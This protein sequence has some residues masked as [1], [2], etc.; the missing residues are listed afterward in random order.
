MM[1]EAQSDRTKPF[2]KSGPAAVISGD[3]AQLCRR[4]VT[5][6]RLE[7]L[8]L[9]ARQVLAE[10]GYTNIEF[11]FGDGTLG[12]PELGPYDGILVTAAAPSIPEPLYEQL[13]PGGRLIVPVGDE[14]GQRLLSVE[15][16]EPDPYVVDL[17][18]CRFVKLIGEA[19]WPG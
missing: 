8:A 7:E 15:K 13:K 12:C 18:G 14:F 5:I 2:W 6:E 11:R 9:R 4:V 1:T 17:G 3:P 10:L 16:H 19:G